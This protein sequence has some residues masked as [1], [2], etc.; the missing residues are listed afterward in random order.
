MN[1][2]DVLGLRTMKTVLDDLKSNNLTLTETVNMILTEAL[3]D[4]SFNVENSFEKIQQKLT[5]SAKML[6]SM[7]F[8]E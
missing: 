6:D 5:N 2:L 1:H 3:K 7:I 8:T 4:A